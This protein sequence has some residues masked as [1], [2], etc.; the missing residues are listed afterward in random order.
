MKKL[1]MF[2]VFLAG[3]AAMLFGNFMPP[4]NGE[5]YALQPGT[6]IWGIQNALAGRHDT[7]ILTNGDSWLFVFR[8]GES[9]GFSGINPSTLKGVDAR[10]IFGNG[11]VA[12]AKT[13]GDV[14]DF[15]K[16]NGW[17]VAGKELVPKS[18]VGLVSN[19]VMDIG[20]LGSALTTFVYIPAGVKIPDE[21]LPAE[22]ITY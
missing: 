20:R 17:V 18:I 2:A 22:K 15:L 12:N 5:V 7:M 8:V 1:L 19:A 14:V 16:T 10:S 9:W 13:V 3:L 4:A 6:T 21:W 11:N